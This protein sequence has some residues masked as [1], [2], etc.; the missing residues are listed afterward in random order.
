MERLVREGGL[1]KRCR[2]KN[3]QTQTYI[4][5]AYNVDTTMRCVS[6]IR[7]V[8][9]WAKL[10]LR[11]AMKWSMWW[12]GYVYAHM[13]P[14]AKRTSHVRRICALR[15][16]KYSIYTMWEVSR[17]T[18]HEQAHTHAHARE[19]VINEETHDELIRKKVTTKSADFYYT[20]L[21]SLCSSAEKNNVNAL[22]LFCLAGVRVMIKRRS[23]SRRWRTAISCRLK[24]HIYTFMHVHKRT[25]MY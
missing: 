8:S 25:C 6:S 23:R 7:C 17:K 21:R 16:Q 22:F 5:P 4:T 13:L 10:L 14:D 20:R 3:A 11:G 2:H 18:T 19:W 1:W 12:Y 24:T 9:M 15:I